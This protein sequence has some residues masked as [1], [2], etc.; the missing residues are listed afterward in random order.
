MTI[1][2]RLGTAL[3]K[4]ITALP[5]VKDS[6]ERHERIAPILRAAQAVAYRDIDDETAKA[7]L[8]EQL[9]QSPGDL[10]EALQAMMRFGPVSRDDYVSDRAYRLLAAS[11][12]GTAV[13][14]MPPERSALFARE[15]SLGRTPINQA[16]AVLK[17]I[18]PRLLDV[19]RKATSAELDDNGSLPPD[20]RRRL[21]VLVGGGAEREDELLRS[22]LASSITQHYLRV[23]AGDS[24]CGPPDMPFFDNPRKSFSVTI[25]IRRSK[26]ATRD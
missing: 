25:P 24:R 11:A 21:G 1:L 9:T 22:S 13:A 16:F 2:G 4:G 10:G 18:E 8:T 6:L 20:I 5:P 3:L 15:E 19:E 17:D 14:P 12:S 23:L 26:G 7:A